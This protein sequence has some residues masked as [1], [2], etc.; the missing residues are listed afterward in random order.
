LKLLKIFDETAFLPIVFTTLEGLL[1][2]AAADFVIG[3]E[4]ALTERV[5]EKFR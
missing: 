3:F 1:V 2:A 5:I 4:G